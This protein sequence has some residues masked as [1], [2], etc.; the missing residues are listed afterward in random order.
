MVRS[1]GLEDGP[2]TGFAHQLASDPDL[3]LEQVVGVVVLPGPPLHGLS[4]DTGLEELTLVTGGVVAALGGAFVVG[5][6]A[7]CLSA[8]DIQGTFGALEIATVGKTLFYSG[9]K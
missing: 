1:L 5:P 8:P 3:V 7:P 9:Q 4:A 6:L 2:L